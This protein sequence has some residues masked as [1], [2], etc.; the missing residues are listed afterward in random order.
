MGQG[1]RP[2][3]AVDPERVVLMGRSAGGHLTLLTACEDGRAAATPGCVARDVRDTGVA[4]VVA[5]YPP[6]DLVRLSSMGY[7]GGMD[8]FLGGS[9]GTVPGRYRHLL[10]PATT[11]SKPMPRTRL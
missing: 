7:L 6:T 9:R 1:E 8:R 10:Y 5:F 2:R 3:Y 4:A 11:R